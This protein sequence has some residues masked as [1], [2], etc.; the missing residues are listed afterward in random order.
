MRPSWWSQLALGLALFALYLGVDVLNSA[1]R[2]ARTAAARR[3]GHSL[4]LLEQHLG[5]DIEH[6]LNERLAPHHLLSTLANYEYASTYVLSA[7]ALIGWV[8]WRRPE[9]WRL[10]RDSFIVL[11]LVAI[12]TF[13]LYPVAPPRMLGDLGFVDTVSRGSTV[14]SWGSGVVDA[15]NQLAAVPSLHVG[16]ALWVSL[17]LARITARRSVQV[18][19]AAHV[20]L[21]LLVVLATANHYLLDAAAVVVPLALGI[22][23]AQAR[24]GGPAGEVVAAPD[25]FFLHVESTGAAQHVGGF[26]RFADATDAPTLA[27]L[28]ELARTELVPQKRFHQRLTSASRWRRLRWV[29]AEVDLDQHVLAWT[30]PVHRAVSSYA[31]KP[32]ARDRPMWRLIRAEDPRTGQAAVAFLVHHSMADGIGTIIHSLSLF[33]PRAALVDGEAATPTPVQR[34]VGTIVGLAQLATD[35][36]VAGRLPAGSPDRGYGTAQLD[37]ETVRLLA[38]ERG[39]RITD[40]VLG[41]IAEAM[42]LTHPDLVTR[43]RGRLR[44]AVPLMVRAP[45]A[46]PEGNATAAVMVDLPLDG[47]PVDELLRTIAGRTGRLR[48]PTRAIASRFVMTTGLRLLPEPAVG[49]FA[50]AAY[51]GRFF[52]GIV[53]NLPGPSEPLTMAGHRPI[54]VFPILPVAPRAPFALGAM[55]WSGAFGWGIAVDAALLDADAIAAR[56]KVLADALANPDRTPDRVPAPLPVSGTMPGEGEEQA[57]A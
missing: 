48:T 1:D 53:S 6:G 13:A 56:V 24:H 17:V 35:G 16:W 33:R 10:T 25:A 43:L 44:V 7:L 9:L 14:G 18:L 32:L 27:D 8:W 31:E 54:G 11:N 40:V 19:S 51:G 34:A 5:I 49:W 39:V 55:S 42:R 21:T 47:R 30:G 23:Y 52:H 26:V 22:A 29:D 15:A 2:A 57:S 12:A 36:G 28:R 45:G 4:F 46:A 38:R 50:R 41:L 20:L 3:H 37:L